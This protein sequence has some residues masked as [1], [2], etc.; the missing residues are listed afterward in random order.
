MMRPSEQ[1]FHPQPGKTALLISGSLHFVRLKAYERTDRGNREIRSQACEFAVCELDFSPP[2][3][4]SATS[5]WNSKVAARLY[6]SSKD[7]RVSVD[8]S[9]VS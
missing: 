4:S 6:R 5:D 8:Q 2:I 1:T 7:I 3:T 9:S